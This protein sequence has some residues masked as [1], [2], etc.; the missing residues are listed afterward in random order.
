MPDSKN[1]QIAY[2]WFKYPLEEIDLSQRFLK[3]GF[4]KFINNVDSNRQSLLKEAEKYAADNN[5]GIWKYYQP[6]ENDTLDE[7]LRSHKTVQLIYLD[8]TRIRAN[9]IIR[10]TYLSIPA[11]L[12]AGSGIT[13]V[14]T[15]A[16]ALLAVAITHDGWA[17][18]GAVVYGGT[19]FYLFGFPYGIY[20]VAKEDNPNLSYWEMIGCGVG[21]TAIMGGITSLLPEGETLNTF[22]VLTFFSPIIGSLLYVHAFP[23]KPPTIEEL[24]KQ[25]IGYQKINSFKD[26]YNATI[27]FRTE[28][29]RI[30]F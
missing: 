21:L 5:N 3:K 18:L 17:A 26:Y 1:H 7:D 29:L 2:L 27:N 23:P 6:N 14:S 15:T 9:F 28:L 19:A 16:T 30:Y 10:P 24:I 20:L 11:E 4:G 12:L 25:N 8:S 13:I 22:G